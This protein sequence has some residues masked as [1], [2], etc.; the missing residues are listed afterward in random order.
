MDTR[1]VGAVGSDVRLE[2]DC[3]VPVVGV[4]EPEPT[5]VRPHPGEPAGTGTLTLWTR[6]NKKET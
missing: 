4:L 5:E 6:N 2:P 3:R 1:G